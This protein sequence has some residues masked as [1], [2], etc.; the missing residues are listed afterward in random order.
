M[1]APTEADD[2]A[3]DRTNSC[4]T[5]DSDETVDGTDSGWDASPD[6]GSKAR[7]EVYRDQ[8][9]EWRW[10]LVHVN[11]NIIADSGEGYNRKAGAM[12]GLKSVKRNAPG[13]AVEVL[14]E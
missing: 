7:F 9:R 11:G 8:A 4:G 5:V 6:G 1:A 3:D 10:R 12:K 14:E 13:A 2:Y